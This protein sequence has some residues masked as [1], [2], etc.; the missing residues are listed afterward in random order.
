MPV[1]LLNPM[2]EE[3]ARA[4]LD[5]RARPAA[6][7]VAQP[8]PRRAPTSHLYE[9]GTVFVTAEGRKQPKERTHRRR[10][11]SPASWHRP[12]WDDSA[13]ARSTS[14]TARACSRRSWR[15][16]AIER[17]RVRAAERPWLQP[18][19]A[20]EVLVGGD[21]VGWL[22][23]VHPR[24]LD[25]YEA[26]GPV[27]LFELQLK[28]LLKAAPGVARRSTTS[29]AI[30]A[31]ELDLALVVPEDV[32]AER[33]EQAI[34]SAGGKLLEGVRLFD[35]YRG[36]GVAEG[37]KSLAFSLTYRAA[38]RTLTDDEVAAVARQARAQGH[39]RRRRGAAH[40]R[41]ATSA[42]NIAGIS[43]YSLTHMLH[44]RIE[45]PFNRHF[46]TKEG[47]MIDVAIVGAAGYTGAELTRLVAGH[48]RLSLGDGDV[49]GGRGQRA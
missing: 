29:R 4:A 21:V 42:Q 45:S 23:E 43:A 46:R 15:R 38:D 22:G 8:A 19:R 27:V 18:G 37:R 48:P 9:I 20:A 11:R 35:V 13:A 49:D 5:A 47:G 3:Q 31:V 10:R 7:R 26:R 39:R 2:S 16:S 41:S 28:P 40:L 36:A 12:A 32:T 24:V 17:W 25:A 34:R 6:R 44:Y 14:S 30:P 1:E 33:V